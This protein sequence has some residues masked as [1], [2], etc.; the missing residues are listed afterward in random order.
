M[1]SESEPRQTVGF[2]VMLLHASNSSLHGKFVPQTTICR[3]YRLL[4]FPL[5]PR[6]LLGSV[7]RAKTPLVKLSEASRTQIRVELESAASVHTSEF[8]RKC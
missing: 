6:K 2:A 1:C 8:F 7:W 3:Q 5:I 4:T